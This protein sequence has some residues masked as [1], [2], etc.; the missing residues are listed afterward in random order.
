MVIASLGIFGGLMMLLVLIHTSSDFVFQSHASAMI[1]HNHPWVRAKH[2][3]IY[4]ASFLPFL[5]WW[6]LP[7]WQLV[8]AANILFWSH[9]A[10]DTYYGV[11]LWALHIRKP[12]CMV[13]PVR[14]ERGTFV[15]ADPKA[16]FIKFIDNALGKI[17]MVVIDQLSHVWFLLPIAYMLLTR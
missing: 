3:L 1:K 10:I 11:F 4:M 8:L 14:T 7:V 15:P 6:G 16:G 2:C 5:I 13:D 17:L 12:P 9:F